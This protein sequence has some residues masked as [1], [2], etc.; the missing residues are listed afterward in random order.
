[1]FP[2]TVHLLYLFWHDSLHI[3]WERAGVFF[4]DGIV[5]P[6]P[7]PGP[8][9]E[10]RGMPLRRRRRRRSRRRRRR[11][12]PKSWLLVPVVLGDVRSLARRGFSLADSGLYQDVVDK[13]CEVAHGARVRARA[14]VRV[15]TAVMQVSSGG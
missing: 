4:I 3:Y 15:R 8:Q 11:R 10:G 6:Q 13:G 9:S 7:H 1:M 14:K 2:P 12:S 5:L